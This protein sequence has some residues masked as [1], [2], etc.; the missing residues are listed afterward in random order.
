MSTAIKRPLHPRATNGIRSSITR[1]LT[2]RSDGRWCK[3]FKGKKY[4]FSGTRDQAWSAWEAKLIGLTRLDA[5][6][7]AKRRVSD[8][9]PSP[10]NCDLYDPVLPKSVEPLAD[11]MR[12][13]GVLTPL[14]VTLDNYVISGHRRL[15]AAKQAGIDE[16]PVVVHPIF[17]DD[18]PDEFVRL[19]IA[20]NNQRIKTFAENLREEAAL[21]DPA[22]AYRRLLSE[23]ADRSKVT[24]P[25]MVLPTRRRRSKISEA[26]RP[27]LDAILKVINDYGEPLSDRKLHYLLLNDPPL[28]NFK[29]SNSRY[30]NDSNSYNDLT[31]LSREPDLRVSS[32]G[33]QSQT[34]RARSRSGWYALIHNL[35]SEGSSIIF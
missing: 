15:V 17:R 9:K 5:R 27:M 21:I 4:Y 16:V 30:V 20:H 24:L 19:L 6:L 14:T 23:R 35:S 7:A 11:D 33:M 34:I 18:D 31:N 10:E 1:P 26:K 22:K 25:P 2:R 13:N 28:R 8:L 12:I 3:Q 29:K 32:H